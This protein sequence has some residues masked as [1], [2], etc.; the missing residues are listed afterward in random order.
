MMKMETRSP[1]ASPTTQLALSNYMAKVYMW[2]T[3]GIM[4]TGFVS[5][6]IATTPDVLYAILSNKILF[7]GMMI[8]EIGLVIWLSTGI[9][10]MTSLMA[11]AMFL[12]YAA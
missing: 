3:I 5:Y 2:M 6:T 9:N 10:R 12:L 7:Y 1:Y 8:A 4:L 11:T